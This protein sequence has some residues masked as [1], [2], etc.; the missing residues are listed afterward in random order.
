MITRCAIS[1]FPSTPTASAA[2]L[3]YQLIISPTQKRFLG[4]YLPLSK[5][6]FTKASLGPKSVKAELC[7]PSAR[8]YFPQFNIVSLTRSKAE[9]HIPARCPAVHN[10]P[11][12]VLQ[13]NAHST[14]CQSRCS[15]N[16]GTYFSRQPFSYLIRPW[17]SGALYWPFPLHPLSSPL[18]PLNRVPREI[19]GVSV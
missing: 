3:P 7:A 4:L 18:A 16:A 13:R 15:L 9:F 14:E 5:D 11:P 19:E 1:L 12:F 17:T 2:T 10:Q 6:Y 8:D